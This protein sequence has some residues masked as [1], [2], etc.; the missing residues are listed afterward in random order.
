MIEVFT[1]GPLETNCYLLYNS[2]EGV[3]IDAGGIDLESLIEFIEKE[4]IKVK[5]VLATHGHFDHVMGVR[6]L[7][8]RYNTLFLINE[9]DLE[10]LKDAVRIAKLF[11]ISIDNVPEPD[12]FIK[13]DDTI[14]VG[15]I[16]IRVIETPGHTMGSLC[17]LAEDYL[18]TGDTL[19][20]GTIGRTDL[21][22]S[23]ELMIESLK[24]LK[25][26]DD[27][28]KIMPGHGPPSILGYEKKYNPFLVNL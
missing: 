8:E 27:K 12:A 18:F 10:L 2:K 4:N 28:L 1:V 22:G 13:G 3:V 21:G 15:N 20:S 7:K 25:M 11:S 17:F 23:E 9:K 16:K 14:E 26:M 5:Y 24:K 6:L 19:F